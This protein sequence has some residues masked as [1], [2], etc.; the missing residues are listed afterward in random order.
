MGR[1]DQMARQKTWM[2]LNNTLGRYLVMFL[3]LIQGGN[4][5]F[6]YEATTRKELSLFAS[7]GVLPPSINRRVLFEEYVTHPSWPFPRQLVPLIWHAVL[8]CLIEP[9][10]AFP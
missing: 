8:G 10:P 7:Y 5:Q 4:R 1:I 6:T 9:I 2:D 3:G